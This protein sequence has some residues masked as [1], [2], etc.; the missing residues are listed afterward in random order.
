MELTFRMN[1]RVKDGSP[2]LT[3]DVTLDC[4]GVTLEQA[5][6]AH[7]RGQS[8]RVWLQA[9]ARDDG[10]PLKMT[11]K[12]MDYI[13]NTR[14]AAARDMT[15]TEIADKA[16]AKAYTGAELDMMIAK[17]QAARAAGTAG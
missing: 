5:L 2:Q 10:V 14:R 13:L 6:Q 8:L 17:L 3:T 16:S 9:R 12:L 4:T 15:A 7:T 11:V 1:T